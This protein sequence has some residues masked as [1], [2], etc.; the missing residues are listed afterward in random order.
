MASG[1]PT[2]AN[3]PLDGS[4]IPARP[5]RFP[6]RRLLLVLAL[7]LGTCGW[8][9]LLY[10]SSW[11]YAAGHSDNANSVLA[12]YDLFHGNV[13]L[14]GW[15]MTA[16]TYWSI[17]LPF[18]GVFTALWGVGPSAIHAVPVAIGAALVVV[19]VA[20]AVRDRRGVGGWIGSGVVLLLLGV[21]SPRASAYFLHGPQH[22]GTT[23]FC[24]VAFLLLGT[25]A[26]R[27]RWWLGVVLLGAAVLGDPLALAIGV[28]PVL[29]AGVLTGLRRRRWE[30]ALTLGA[31]ALLAVVGAYLVHLAL[32]QADSYA[33]APL[34][35]LPPAS[36]WIT[37]LRVAPRLLLGLLGA[38]SDSG[39]SGLSRAGHVL[40]ALALVVAT[41]DATARAVGGVLRPRHLRLTPRWDAGP[42][43]LDDMLLLAF[44]GG[45][46]TY[47]L[48]AL[49]PN[50]LGGTRYL[51]PS[52]AYGA[53][54]TG[55]RAVAA[56]ECLPRRG[57]PV[58]AAAVLAVGGLYLATSVDG[59]RGPAPVDPERE[60]TD[61]LATNDLHSGFG[62]YWSASTMTV[63]SGGSVNIRP[64]TSVDGRLRGNLFFASAKWFTSDSHRPRRFLVYVP[65]EHPYDGVDDQS[66]VSAFGPPVRTAQVGAYRVLVWDRDLA[67]LLGP[68]WSPIPRPGSA[69]RLS[70]PVPNG[71]RAIAETSTN[72][73]L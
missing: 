21:P 60:L 18:F 45:L 24:V 34:V 61:W 46:L 16:N 73:D 26:G 69:S 25:R 6:T 3:Q 14:A 71:W 37:N 10:A 5:G 20:C 52:F 39:L 27:L 29:G 36:Q 42:S 17:D 9:V 68:P 33:L 59:L 49:P 31:A 65:G 62:P 35:P 48:I 41:V 56:V 57:V 51:L 38:S 70:W 11:R 66:A 22:V 64:L 28:A 67:P 72:P 55:R 12:G 53:I 30:P 32:Q 23:L 15:T 19:G 8:L 58:A 7:A 2:T 1:Q 43:A 50:D 13:L 44:A 47:V 63:K 40:G 4:A 54:L